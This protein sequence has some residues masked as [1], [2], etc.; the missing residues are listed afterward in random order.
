MTAGTIAGL[1]DE[2]AAI[3]PGR[4]LLRDTDGRTLTVADVADLTSAATTG[5]GTPVYGPG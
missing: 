1:L 2:S 3:R 4:P 5:S